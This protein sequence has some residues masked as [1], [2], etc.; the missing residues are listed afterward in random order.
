[1]SSNTTLV[2]LEPW[3][4]QSPEI[5]RAGRKIDIGLLAE[6]LVFYD[7]VYFA[8]TSAEQFARVVAWFKSQG[9]IAELIA[10]LHDGTL[11]PY[12]YAFTTH[13]THIDERWSVVNIQDVESASSPVYQKRIAESSQVASLIQKRSE[14]AALIDAAQ[15]NHLEV[16]A[17]DFGAPLANADSDYKDPQRAAY[18]VQIVVDELYKEL[19]FFSPPTIH[20]SIKEVGDAHVLT[21]NF[22][23]DEFAKRLGR[24]MTFHNG[25]PLVGASFGVKTLWSAAQLQS[26]IYVGRPLQSYLCSKMAEGN[27]VAR[28]RTIIGQLTTEV[29][30]PDIRRLVNHGEIGVRHVLELRKHAAQFREWLRN[31]SEIDRNAVVAYSEEVAQSA[32]WHKGMRKLLSFSA[33][34]G[35]AAAAALVTDRLTAAAGVAAAAASGEALKYLIDL[36]TKVEEGWRP[37]V[38]GQTATELIRRAATEE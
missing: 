29:A 34:M 10:L 7:R 27:K 9:K 24:E 20:A 30:F 35:G 38:F 4:Y 11:I 1:M 25:M 32:G 23:F 6:A 36:A 5:Y 17:N 21:Y 3:Y 8:F 16:K 14:R 26:D 12:Y 2:P 33:V 28:T 15:L 13:A 19:G 22:D 18:L 31:E 37:K